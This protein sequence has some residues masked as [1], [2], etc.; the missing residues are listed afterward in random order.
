[1]SK[2]TNVLDKIEE[3]EG[4]FKFITSEHR[5]FENHDHD[6]PKMVHDTM[7]AAKKH[8]R[9][10]ENHWDM[11]ITKV[12]ADVDKNGMHKVHSLHH[13]DWNAGGKSPYWQVDKAREG[14]II[15]AV[16]PKHQF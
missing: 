13:Q 1:M 14:D 15:P 9:K 16:Y 10:Y 6:V 11:M 8:C 5:G 2:A 12:H 3:N 7:D 4:K